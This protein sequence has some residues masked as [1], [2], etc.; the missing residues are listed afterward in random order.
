MRYLQSYS[1]FCK[2]YFGTSLSEIMQISVRAESVLG[3]LVL[4]MDTAVRDSIRFAFIA[5]KPVLQDKQG[6]R[7]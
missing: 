5:L 3:R 4:D 6:H 7:P 1:S 2:Q